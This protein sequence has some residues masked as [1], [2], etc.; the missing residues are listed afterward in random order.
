MVAFFDVAQVVRYVELL[1]KA[2]TAARVGFYLSQHRDELMIDDKTLAALK[3]MIPK[4]P[5]Y[6]GRGA[7]TEGRLVSEWNLLVSPEILN[8][9]WE[10]VL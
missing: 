9:T 6:M 1:K 10:D 2:T 4:Q 8:R 3:E 7:R 5:H